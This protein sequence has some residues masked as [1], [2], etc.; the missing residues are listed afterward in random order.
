MT[1][2]THYILVRRDLPLGV[3]A[4]MIAHAAGESGAMYENPEDGRFRH[5]I[6]VV[7]GVKSQ[8]EL[9]VAELILRKNNIPAVSIDESDGPYAGQFLAIGV[10][11]CERVKVGTLLK[12]FQTLKT[13]DNPR[14]EA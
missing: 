5:A 2:L 3:C 10:V 4:A 9:R 7:L 12:E 13:L 1:S 11:P 6:V 14:E 8:S